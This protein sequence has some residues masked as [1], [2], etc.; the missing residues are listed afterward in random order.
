MGK[1]NNDEFWDKLFII[2]YDIIQQLIKKLVLL[3]EP[4]DKKINRKAMSRNWSNQK[5]NP[6]LKTK[7]GNK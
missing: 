3:K 4:Q 2:S 1:C 6:A 5:A 7:A